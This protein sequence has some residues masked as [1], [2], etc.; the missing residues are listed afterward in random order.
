MLE[1]KVAVVTGAFGCLGATVA[2]TLLERG[3]RVAL[4]DRA[5]A[6]EQAPNAGALCLGNVDI[7]HLAAAREAM[8]AVALAFGRIDV[9]VNVA[10]GFV[11][12]PFSDADTE[13]WDQMFSMNLKTAVVASTAALKHLRAAGRGRIINVGAASAVDPAAGTGAYA[14]SKAGVRCFTEALAKELAE[15]GITVN[16][17]L[18]SIIDTPRNRMDMPDADYSAWVQPSKVADLIAALASDRTSCVTGASIA[19]GA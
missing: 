1:G 12:R 7:T 16:E 18:P 8:D 14:A 9:L 17:V 11:W 2:R 19:I 15:H 10:G 6:T 4:V 5:K 3:A 13:V